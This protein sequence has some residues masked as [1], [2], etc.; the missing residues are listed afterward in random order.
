MQDG[1]TG[2]VDRSEW[3]WVTLVS[4][5]FLVFIF[6]PFIVI[7][8]QNPAQSQQQFMGAMHDYQNS[9]AD[10]AR[11]QEG[12]EGRW[13]LSF[14]FSPEAH[15]RA[16]VH[17]L[18]AVLG[19][20]AGFV[21]Q[22]PFLIYHIM[23]IFSGLFMYLT[24]YHLGASIWVKVRTRRIF[25]VTSS[26]GAGFGWIVALATSLKGEPNIPDLMIPQ[27]FPIYAAAAN[28]HY[29]LAI[30][31]LCLL[32]SI[33]IPMLRPG[34]HAT[35]SAENGGV[36][37]FFAA[38]VLAFV[39]PD[40]LLPISVALILS[41]LIHWGLQRKASSYEA[42]WGL[43][44]LVPALPIITYDLMTLFYNPF[45][46]NW[47]QQRASQ[48]P[49]IWMLLVSVGLPLL[50]ALPGLFRAVRR[51][52]AD[53]DRFMLLWLLSMVILM[54]LPIQLGHYL[55]VGLMLP[56]G[57]FATRSIEDFWLSFIKRRF[58]SILYVLIVPLLVMSHVFWLY[59]PVFPLM[60]GWQG[61]NAMMLPLDVSQALLWL[62]NGIEDEAIILAPSDISLWIPS[63]VG[64]RV[65]YGHSIETYQSEEKL[66]EVTA[67]YA[68]SDTSQCANLITDYSVA[69]VVLGAK[70]I[71]AGVPCVEG[72]R[73]I[74]NR[75]N[76]RI[77]ATKYATAFSSSED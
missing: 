20:L 75:G 65:V 45:V 15:Q 27:A 51:F 2:F 52:E 53:G 21:G 23:R 32:T 55:L 34:S 14:Q 72:L 68:E 36:V 16:F 17:P 5:T 69:Y 44:I 30:A 10:L 7:A 12:A 54:Y 42:Y 49:S 33:I 25:F 66:A 8:L 48:V 70:E 59:L 61:I 11:M 13:L 41:V 40:A 4:I 3:W 1:Y 60:R 50:I 22:S 18:Y 43:W 35:P 9:A 24:I 56:I 47:V 26:I 74:Y 37:C 29:P 73:L 63:W 77:Y 31:C 19:H 39:Y 76:V 46:A 67:W 64:G 58:R 62:D 38:L 6:S 28:V 57:Y 71:A